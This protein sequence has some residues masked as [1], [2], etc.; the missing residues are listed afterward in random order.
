MSENEKHRGKKRIRI[1]YVRAAVC[2]SVLIIAATVLLSLIPAWLG[3]GTSFDRDLIR[4]SG[5]TDAKPPEI[6]AK[7]AIMYSLD[8]DKAVYEKDADKRM[9]PYSMTKLLTCYLA[10][11]NLDPEQ[12]VTAS[13][14]ATEELEDGMEIELEVGEQLKAIDLIY[15][16]ML[17][18]AN[19]GATALG[20]AVSGSIEKFTDLMN[21]TAADWGCEN[22]HFVNAN[23][24]DNKNH[25]TTARDMAIITKHC[26][27][28]EKLREIALTKKYTLPASNMSGELKME[29]AFLKTMN[30]L[31]VLT[32][33]KTGSW[34]E[35][36]CAIALEFTDRGLSSVI[37]LLGDTQKGRAK[38][39]VKLINSAH[40]ITPGFLV[41]KKGDIACEAWVKHGT[42]N[43][44]PLSVKNLC[45][46][47]PKNEKP[48]GVKVKTE[49]D[50]LEA[51]LKKGDRAGKYYVYAN[52]ELVGKGYLYVA[53]DIETGWFPSYLYVPDNTSLIVAMVIALLLLLSFILQKK[54]RTT[55]E[56]RA[57]LRAK[58]GYQ[59]KH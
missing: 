34:S 49:I 55:E 7:S 5:G 52:K 13:E 41:T 21:K 22:T 8:L 36:Q 39:P 20:E 59:S 35:S 47:Y 42:K 12:I 30:D 31:K 57:A 18:S 37:V 53:E 58:R 48:A 54:S 44:V 46:A 51:P 4:M 9:P 6:T 40:E 27:E 11:E 15:A 25:Y 56:R 45:Y 43:K 24:W 28:N 50:K 17:M 2:L 3:T 10:L 23:G 33:G 38:D 1:R 29:N 26:L 32:G 16:A 14:K 19:D